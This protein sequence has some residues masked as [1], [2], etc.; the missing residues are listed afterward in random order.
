M[1]EIKKVSLAIGY[2]IS[3]H[4]KPERWPMLEA[5]LN[6]DLFN[7][8]CILLSDRHNPPVVLNSIAIKFEERKLNGNIQRLYKCEI[9][10][11]IEGF[12]KS[13]IGQSFIDVSDGKG[14]NSFALRCDIGSND[15]EIK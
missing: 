5:S 10:G 9:E 12:L 4:D 3:P 8:L 14:D 15:K 7:R 13:P 2:T 6:K 1:S 11:E